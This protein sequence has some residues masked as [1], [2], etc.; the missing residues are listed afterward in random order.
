MFSAGVVVV[1]LA[2]VNTLTTAVVVA[3]VA[4]VTLLKWLQG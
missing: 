4:V 3:V 2:Q 1:H